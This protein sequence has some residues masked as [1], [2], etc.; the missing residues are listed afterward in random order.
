[1]VA[2]KTRLMTQKKG[3]TTGA[4]GNVAMTLMMAAEGNLSHFP[5][6]DWA[7]YTEEGAE[8]TGNS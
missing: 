4:S 7:C 8:A 3:T 6:T 1:M 2:K 5:P